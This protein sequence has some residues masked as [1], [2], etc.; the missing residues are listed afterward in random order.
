MVFAEAG[1]Q[2]FK[3]H[4]FAQLQVCRPAVTPSLCQRC[5]PDRIVCLQWLVFRSDGLTTAAAYSAAAAEAGSRGRGVGGD[6]LFD[7]FSPAKPLARRREFV[8]QLLRQVMEGL[9]YMHRRFRLHQSLGPASVVLNS[10]DERWEGKSI[11][12]L[13]KVGCKDLPGPQM[14]ELQ[15]TQV[16][17]SPLQNDCRNA[18]AALCDAIATFA[19]SS[20]FNALNCLYSAS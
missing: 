10:T 4:L 7:R 15:L 19:P 9:A 1:P 2:A 20:P 12:T 6:E 13:A 11:R 18:K 5:S 17:F 3:P 16:W 14:T 8:L